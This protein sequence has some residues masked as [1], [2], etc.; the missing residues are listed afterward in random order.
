MRGAR[1]ILAISAAVTAI[2]M[3]PSSAGASWRW[4]TWIPKWYHPFGASGYITC[5]R[6]I[7]GVW[8]SAGTQSGWAHLRFTNA[9]DT[10]AYY[11]KPFNAP[12]KYRLAIGC[13]GPPDR[14]EVTF[15][16]AFTFLPFANIDY[17]LSCWVG[18]DGRKYCGAAG[19]VG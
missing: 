3:L 12:S 4:P 6:Y 10:G 1:L 9:N 7:S 8:V 16:P 5:D 17:Y 14:W 19:I 15:K 2:A 11:D 18:N 13:G